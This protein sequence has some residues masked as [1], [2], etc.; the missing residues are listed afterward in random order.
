MK[1][2]TGI[3]SVNFFSATALLAK[4]NFFRHVSLRDSFIIQKVLSLENSMEGIVKLGTIIF[5]QIIN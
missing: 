4:D 2:C 1:S 3:V 5:L